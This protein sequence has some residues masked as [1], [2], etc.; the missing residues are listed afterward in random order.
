MESEIDKSRNR[1]EV[2]SFNI[3][4][5]GFWSSLAFAALLVALNV[6][7]A[8]MAIQAPSTEWEGMEAY[9]QKFQAIAFVPQAIGL[10]LIP[11]F[12]LMMTSIHLHTSGARKIWSLT[13]LAFGTASTTLLGSL[14]FIQVGVLLPA[15]IHGYW[16]GLDQ[17][18]FANPRSI[19]WGL[20]HFAWALLGAAL[21]SMARVF[22]GVGLQRWIRWL[23]ALNGLV[24]ISL[25]FAFAFELDA[26]TLGVALL[27]WVIALPLAAVLVALMFRRGCTTAKRSI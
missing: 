8:I 4:T 6:S 19:A 5:I 12:I 25:I 2:E 23:F 16:Q 21:F 17:Y 20:N 11:A 24:N 9:S 3:A 18:A 13:G 1:R 26:L 7:F 14:Y 27:S 22:D 15:L 10:V